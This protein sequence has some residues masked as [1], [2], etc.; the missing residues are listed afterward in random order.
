LPQ[1]K[2]LSFVAVTKCRPLE[3]GTRQQIAAI[4]R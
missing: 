4:S 1:K 3:T 2:L